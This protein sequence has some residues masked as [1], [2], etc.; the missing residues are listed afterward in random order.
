MRKRIG[1]PG[2]AAAAFIAVLGIAAPAS[3]G[4]VPCGDPNNVKVFLRG[5]A[6]IC[7]AKIGKSD[8]NKVG[9]YRLQAGVYGGVVKVPGRADTPFAPGQDIRFNPAV[10]PTFVNLTRIVRPARQGR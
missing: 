3:A 2:L 10:N 8:F 6:T 7:F 5:G 1:A 4:Q 9:V